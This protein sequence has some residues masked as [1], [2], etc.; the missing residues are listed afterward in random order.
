MQ[1]Y[2]MSSITHSSTPHKWFEQ[3]I[4]LPAPLAFRSLLR[5]GGL[6]GC[7]GS[8]F[9]SCSCTTRAVL[10]TAAH[11]RKKFGQQTPLLA[12]HGFR[13]C[14]GPEDIQVAMPVHS[15]QCYL[16]NNTT[17][18]S[19]IHSSTSQKSLRQHIPLL[20][21]LS[22]RHYWVQVDAQAAGAV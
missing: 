2:Y 10:H 22:S 1:L 8:L 11:P 18:N 21:R 7:N 13:H 12:P 4:P 19:V 9:M 5:A 16:V 17:D 6:L 15:C 20:C 3:Q 14:C